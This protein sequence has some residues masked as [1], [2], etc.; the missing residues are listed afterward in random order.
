MTPGLCSDCTY[1]LVCLSSQTQLLVGVSKWLSPLLCPQTQVLRALPS[2]TPP[3]PML[4]YLVHA[5]SL[6]P[7]YRWVLGLPPLCHSGVE[8]QYSGTVISVD[9][10]DE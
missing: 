8:T 9:S 2:A 5:L 6:S 10:A 3:T 1:S 7:W 4:F